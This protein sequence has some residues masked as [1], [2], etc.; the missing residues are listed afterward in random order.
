MIFTGNNPKMFEEFK[1]NMIKEFEMTD[2]GEMSYFL[3]VEVSQSEKGIFISQK[4]YAKDILQK[5]NMSNCNP[6]AT[7]AEVGVKLRRDTPGSYIDPTLYK[8]LVGSLRYLT[9]TRP[10][11]VFAVGLV[12]RYMEEPRQEHFKAAKRILRYVRGSID[13]GLFYTQ[14]ADS[15]LVGYTDSDYGG[16]LDERKSTSGYMFNIGSATFSWSSKKQSVVALSSCEAEYIAASTCACQAIWLRSLMKEL[17][18]QQEAPT[19]ILIALM[20]LRHGDPAESA[21]CRGLE[22]PDTQDQQAHE[23]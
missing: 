5:F 19:E 15:R 8:S 12:S 9:I 7:P 13:Q 20:H 14:C 1:K 22:S 4:K 11:I 23:P 2:I 10:D 18:H 3:G 21:G 17:Q 16:D 6:V